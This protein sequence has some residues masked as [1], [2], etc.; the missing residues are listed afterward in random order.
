MPAE[1]KLTTRQKQVLS[2][3]K[4][5]QRQTGFVPTLQETAKHFGFKSLNSVRQHLRLIEKKGFVHRL[6]G[7]SRALIV[8]GSD[9]RNDTDVVRVPLLGRIPAGD[10]VVANEDTEALLT[11]PAHLF[12]GRQL[13]ALR[14]H[15][16]S[17]KG[18]GILNGD[19]AVFDATPDVEDGTIAAVLIE[20]EATLKRVY[21][22]SKCLLLKAENP[23]FRDIQVASCE[24][25]RARI[26]GAL[27]GVVRKV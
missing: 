9:G 25:Q 16:A 4:D 15:G 1:I 5:Q 27:V 20:D 10:P 22:K 8:T 13:F 18:A 2:Y 6:P 7:R 12:R 24:T 21:R 17:M 23:A 11:L 14:V 3:V 26:I 19:I